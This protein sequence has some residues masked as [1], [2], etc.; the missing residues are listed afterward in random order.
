M[1]FASLCVCNHYSVRLSSAD[2]SVCRF[3]AV[4]IGHK[5]NYLPPQIFFC[6]SPTERELTVVGEHWNVLQER[7]ND[8]RATLDTSQNQQIIEHRK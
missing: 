7:K 4:N 3:P 1:V 8:L 6:M 2:F 5:V